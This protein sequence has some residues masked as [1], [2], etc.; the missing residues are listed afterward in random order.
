MKQKLI[1]ICKY[2][3]KFE[4]YVRDDG[5]I[6][7]V[8]TNKVLSPQLDKD[9]YQ[10]VQM[11]STDGKRHRYSVHRLV[12]ENFNPVEGMENLQVNH[13]DGNKENNKLENLEW[14]TC[15]E[16]IQHAIDNNLRAKIN[17]A[18]K[19]TIEQVKEIFIR[20]HRGEKN[21]DLGRE[22]NLH[23]DSIGKI[24]NQKLWKQITKDL[25]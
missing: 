6:Y 5:T 9:G 21:V 1:T 20:S 24:K 19:L 22:Y 14:T 2:E 11:M 10:K 4:Y 7:S 12:L 25:I 13:I 23:P 3:L 8:R 18:S 15:K 16:N 17:G